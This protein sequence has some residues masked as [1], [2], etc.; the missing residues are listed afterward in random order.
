MKSVRGKYLTFPF[1]FV[2]VFAL[3]KQDA[4]MNPLQARINRKLI[5][6]SPEYTFYNRQLHKAYFNMI[7]KVTEI[8]RA[9]LF[10]FI[11]FNLYIIYHRKNFWKN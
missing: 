2:F 5:F 11:D 9:V 6:K 8:P 1:T 3:A 7:L 10:R 4:F